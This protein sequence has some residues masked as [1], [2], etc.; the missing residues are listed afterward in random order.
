[1]QGAWEK[2]GPKLTPTSYNDGK[3]DTDSEHALANPTGKKSPSAVILMTLLAGDAR[4]Y[5]ISRMDGA[6]RRH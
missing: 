5:D 2:E 4:A 3:V 6:A 1:M